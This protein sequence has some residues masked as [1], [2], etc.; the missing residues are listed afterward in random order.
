MVEIV[1]I[2]VV[3]VMLELLEVLNNLIPS[4]NISY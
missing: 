1:V 3:F 4:G 2:S